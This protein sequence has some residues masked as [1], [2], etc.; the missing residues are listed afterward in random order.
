MG[1]TSSICL[2]FVLGVTFS[3]NSAYLQAGAR[4]T[5]VKS[6]KPTNV[7]NIVNKVCSDLS[8]TLWTKPYLNHLLCEWT[9]RS[10]LWCYHVFVSL[11]FFK[12]KRIIFLV[13]SL[14]SELRRTGSFK[15]TFLAIRFNRS[16]F[17]SLRQASSSMCTAASLLSSSSRVLIVGREKA[18]D[19]L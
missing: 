1:T 9:S 2:F 5:E 3:V 17:T 4:Q 12:K 11:P 13:L 18:Q 8:C 15:C 10:V 6:L 7:P 16:S 14:W 19:F